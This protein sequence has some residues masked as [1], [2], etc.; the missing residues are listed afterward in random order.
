ML[1]TRIVLTEPSHPGNI[2]ATARAMKN[3]GLHELYLVKPKLFPHYDATVRASGADDILQQAVVVDTLEAAL[4]GCEKVY[5]TSARSRRLEWPLCTP[6][7]A[8]KTIQIDAALKSCVI[9]GRES[10]GLTNE[11]L[12]LAHTHIH[13]PTNNAFSSL[14][15]SQAVQV[16]VY[17]IFATSQQAETIQNV[18]ATT[19][20]TVDEQNGFFEHMREVMISVNFLN[21]RQPRKLMQRIR[22][23]FQRAEMTQTEVNI[24]RGFLSSVDKKIK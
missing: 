6:H 17:E 8:A 19:L 15:L 1:T 11:E 3:M 21:P 18:E 4:V 20:A 22:R 12:A 14:N 23:L 13:I 10:S 7:E 5:A 2:G 24:L 9:F 16:I